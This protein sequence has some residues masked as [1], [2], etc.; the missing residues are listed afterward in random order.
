MSPIT[1]F[2][3]KPPTFNK[4]NT[5]GKSKP[6]AAHVLTSDQSLALLEEKEQKKYEEEEAKER[7]KV[8]REEDC[9]GGGQEKKCEER[10]HRAL[11]REET[12]ATQEGDGAEKIL[13]K[14]PRG[15]V[16]D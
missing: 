2:L 6:A 5:K 15:V 1:S 7:K 11:E 3:S 12:S 16:Q 10:Q 9:P 14:K 4:T 13:K 8:E